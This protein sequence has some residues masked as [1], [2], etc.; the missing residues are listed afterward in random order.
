MGRSKE[1]R[2]QEIFRLYEAG[3]TYQEIA[4]KF[5][6]TKQRVYYIVY[7]F[8]NPEDTEERMEQV[9]KV[10]YPNIRR[11]LIDNRKSIK[12]L[13]E[14]VNPNVDS[15]VALSRLLT[16]KTVRGNIGTIQRILEVTGM[17]FE[18]AFSTKDMEVE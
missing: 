9:E 3:K 13:S 10:I 5:D 15:P 2:N 16:D 12:G 18:E 11:W 1:E 6:I 14:L 4:D 7:R 8:L 17:T